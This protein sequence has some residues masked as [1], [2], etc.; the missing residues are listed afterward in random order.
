[1]F[2]RSSVKNSQLLSTW[3]L[4]KLLIQSSALS[5]P[6]IISS[7]EP[8]AHGELIG[9]SWSGVRPLSVVHNAQ[10]SSSP[11]PLDR[12]KPNFMWSLLG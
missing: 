5:E 6:K 4:D 12:T 11:K 7:P 2:R 10:R 9:Y 8:K 3:S 1:M